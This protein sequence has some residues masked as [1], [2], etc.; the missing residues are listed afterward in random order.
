[1]VR[2]MQHNIPGRTKNE[3]IQ[4]VA[5]L[6]ARQVYAN[7]CF[8]SNTNLQRDLR[9]DVARTTTVQFRQQDGTATPVSL[10]Q[11][12]KMQKADNTRK[13]S[14][15]SIA[16]AKAAIARQGKKPTKP[17][18]QPAAA[19]K[20]SYVPTNSTF[21]SNKNNNYTPP[22]IGKIPNSSNRK[23]RNGLSDEPLEFHRTK[24]ASYDEVLAESW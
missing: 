4:D 20:S 17:S 5:S 12:Y 3:I 1:M 9:G 10:E 21:I 24:T 23:T 13:A 19:A 7:P 2:E 8:A 18:S 22:P 14:I 6:S 11:A 15:Q 16:T